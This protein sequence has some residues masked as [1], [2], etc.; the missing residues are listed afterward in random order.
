LWSR[1]DFKGVIRRLLNISSANYEW[2][3][4]R[5]LDNLGVR[6]P[7]PIGFI[8]LGK[9]ESSFTD[10]LIME[11]L[12]KTSKCIDYLKKCILIQNEKEVSRIEAEV[13]DITVSMIKNRI[14]DWDHS[15]VNMLVTQE[16]EVIR[17]DVEQARKIRVLTFNSELYSRM[18]GMLIVSYTYAVQPDLKRVNSFTDKLLF[19]LRPSGKVLKL[20]QKRIDALLLLQKSKNGIDM[21]VTLKKPN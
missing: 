7:R 9:N 21:K 4:L 15:L 14:L 16:G 13:I 18:L 6:V 10:V 17:L 1:P 3:N 2:N 8:N 12:G 5:V 19:E 11:D 20:T